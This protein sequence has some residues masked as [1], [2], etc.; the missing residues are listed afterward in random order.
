MARR[1]TI[2]TSG[3]ELPRIESSLAQR[4]AGAIHVF[5]GA[6]RKPPARS[7]ARGAAFNVALARHKMLFTAAD[8]RHDALAIIQ[9]AI[10]PAR[11]PTARNE[12]SG[13]SEAGCAAVW[14][15]RR[16]GILYSARTAIRLQDHRSG[17]V[18][19]RHQLGRCRVYVRVVA[20]G[21]P[22]ESHAEIS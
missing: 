18:D 6:I 4:R 7:T 3:A 10:E 17:R 8:F 13:K 1:V 16:V 15:R 22:V 19:I 12:C 2:S 20:P 21:Q 5:S 9:Q 14:Q 11:A